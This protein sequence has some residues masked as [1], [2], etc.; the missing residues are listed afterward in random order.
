MPIMYPNYSC[1]YCVYIP[2]PHSVARVGWGSG[3]QIFPGASRQYTIYIHSHWPPA[4]GAWSAAGSDR[5]TPQSII[6]YMSCLSKR[7][8]SIPQFARW[9][10]I[11]F[12]SKQH[13]IS[14]FINQ[15]KTIFWQM[16]LDFFSNS[17]FADILCLHNIYVLRN[18][19][20]LCLIYGL[21]W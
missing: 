18:V 2:N 15:V 12:T 10:S 16:D 20:Y 7:N 21:Y 8:E 11:C 3:D 14:K 17:H 4:D 6:V 13:T 9:F 1:M 19:I 5:R